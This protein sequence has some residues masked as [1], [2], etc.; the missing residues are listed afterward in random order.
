MNVFILLCQRFPNLAFFLL[1]PT[2]SLL[3]RSL[4]HLLAAFLCDSYTEHPLQ[5][6]LHPSWA[7]QRFHVAG[8]RQQRPQPCYLHHLQHRVQ[9]GLHQDPQLLN[10]RMFQ[11]LKMEIR[12]ATCGSFCFSGTGAAQGQGRWLSFAAAAV[13]IERGKKPTLWCV[14][15]ADNRGICFKR[16]KQTHTCTSQQG[17]DFWAELFLK[18]L[19]QTYGLSDS[20]RCWPFLW[21]RLGRYLYCSLAQLSGLFSMRWKVLGSRGG[22][23]KWL[24]GAF[25]LNC[26]DLHNQTNPSPVV[27]LNDRFW[28]DS[29]WKELIPSPTQWPQEFMF[30]K[31]SHRSDK[32]TRCIFFFF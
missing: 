30:T 1:P 9:E 13:Q 6:M 16:F 28:S 21:T 24:Q 4:P 12:L 20:T 19:T 32:I 3:R 18:F 10:A 2:L 17:L 7:L 27:I 25:H 11:E 23:L 5:D 26:N 14:I 15:D 8:V 31:V 29:L 22:A